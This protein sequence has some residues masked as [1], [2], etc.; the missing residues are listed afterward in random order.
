MNLLPG[1]SP[2]CR[3]NQWGRVID[4]AIFSGPLIGAPSIS[5]GFAIVA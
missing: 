1:I 3:R 5:G 2:I 4:D